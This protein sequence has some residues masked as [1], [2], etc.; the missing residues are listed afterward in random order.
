M[1]SRKGSAGEERTR[2]CFRQLSLNNLTVIS[3]CG[4]QRAEQSVARIRVRQLPFGH[5]RTSW[6]PLGPHP[7]T[8]TFFD[9]AFSSPIL[10]VNCLSGQ[11]RIQQFSAT[12][13]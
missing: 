12:A 2:V 11:L 4:R 7:A 1:G 6:L 10:S 3:R 5:Q 9:H 8:G 13:L